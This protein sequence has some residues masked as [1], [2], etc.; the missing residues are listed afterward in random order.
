MLTPDIVRQEVASG[1]GFRPRSL[2]SE[3]LAYTLTDSDSTLVATS[4]VA[5]AGMYMNDLVPVERL[6]IRMCGYS[7]CFRRE[8]GSGHSNR[9]LY[10]LHQ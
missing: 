7:H 4:E 6:P 8:G 3:S 2:D 1:C 9:G 5:L 10:R